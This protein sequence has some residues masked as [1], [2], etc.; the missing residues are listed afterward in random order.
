MDN[1]MS[2]T[3]EILTSDSS[4]GSTASDQ[5]TKALSPAAQRALA[6][7]AE[8][9]DVQARREAAL[10]AQGEVN[11]RGGKDPVRYNDWEIKGL[12]SDF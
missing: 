2:A 8:R 7:A 5:P 3:P 10:A 11:G 4:A 12:T 1:D 9:R 6:E